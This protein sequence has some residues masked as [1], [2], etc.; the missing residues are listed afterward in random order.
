M[1]RHR[2]LALATVVGA[3]V[4]MAVPGA[5]ANAFSQCLPNS[6]C[7]LSY[8]ANAQY[9]TLVGTTYHFCNGTTSTLGEVTGFVRVQN[10]PCG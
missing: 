7:V 8:Y 5:A 2:N 10:V 1:A 3:V 6:Q 9:T 4:A